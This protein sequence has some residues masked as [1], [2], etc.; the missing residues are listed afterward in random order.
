[1]RNQKLLLASAVSL[2][3]ASA[4]PASARADGW[5]W[6][7]TPYLW[8][9]SIKAD[10]ETPRGN[11]EPS[12]GNEFFPDVLDEFKGAFLG[13]VEG[14]GERFGMFA[15]ITWMSLGSSEE[16]PIANTES[17]LDATIFELAGVW[18]PGEGAYRGFDLLAGLRYVD[19]GYDVEIDPTNPAFQTRSVDSGGT[20]SDFMVGA[21]WTGYFG[22]NEKWGL[23]LRGDGSWGETEGTWSASALMS[24]KAGP[25]AWVF[26]YK[27]LDGEIKPNRNTFDITVHG[28][29]VGYSF[30]L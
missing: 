25:G 7:L 18:S 2:L 10:L 3:V 23:Q 8:L 12:G 14:Q 13:H 17:D 26:G 29:I 1:M 9:P 21:R 27:Y 11:D 28:P 20:F 22:E 19:I 30:A 15:D 5:E 24:Y 6:R 4:F 16:F